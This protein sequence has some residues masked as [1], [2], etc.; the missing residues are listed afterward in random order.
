MTS[1]RWLAVLGVAVLSGC[2]TVE[3]DVTVFHTADVEKPNTFKVVAMPP[4]AGSLEAQ[5]YSDMIAADLEA[6][7]WTQAANG[8]ITVAF[9][10]DADNGHSETA[11]MPIFGQTGGGTS[12]TFGTVSTGGQ[13][14]TYSGTT[15]TA[16]TY[17]VVSEVPVT[18][19]IY[20]RTFALSMY[21]NT[22]NKTLYES[23]VTS[24]GTA[25][26]FSTVAKCL[27]DALFADFPGKNAE[28]RTVAVDG[29][30]CMLK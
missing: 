18:T 22:S 7:G 20:N 27:I 2:T 4:F 15:Y 24:S 12:Q 17:G 10:Y 13:F 8:D 14:G 29:D 23:K 26:Q 11:A 19:T 9:G 28:H 21:G 3:S 16:P 6:K 5:T 1:W 25:G 30:K